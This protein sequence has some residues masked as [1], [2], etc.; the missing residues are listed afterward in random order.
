MKGDVSKPVTIT[1]DY[2]M[3]NMGRENINVPEFN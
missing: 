3:V 1:V 2:Q